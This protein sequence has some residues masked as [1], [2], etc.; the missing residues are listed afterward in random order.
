MCF[1]RNS[2]K[3][4]F[5]APCLS[6]KGKRDISIPKLIDLHSVHAFGESRIGAHTRGHTQLLRRKGARAWHD[7]V[8]SELRGQFAHLCATSCAELNPEPS[9]ARGPAARSMT[10]RRSLERSA[11][12]RRTGSVAN[13]HGQCPQRV[14]ATQALSIDPAQSGK[15]G[16]GWT[17][18]RRCFALVPLQV[19]AVPGGR[20]LPRGRRG[21]RGL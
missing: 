20:S 21:I 16:F 5:W 10:T 4:F 11:L 17:D 3:K 12:P 19:G 1:V 7:I 2:A 15:P 9:R 14:P 13:T 8:C 6:R 18:G